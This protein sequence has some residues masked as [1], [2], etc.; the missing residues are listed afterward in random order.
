MKKISRIL[1]TVFSPLIIPTYGMILA[2]YLSILAYLPAGVLWSSIGVVFVITCLVPATAIYA[3]FKSGFVS[4]AGLNERTD[5]T[6]PYI[7][8][9]LCYLGAG[10]FLLRAA[11]PVWLVMFFAGGALA[12]LVSTIVNRW[13][14]ISAHAA[15]MGGLVAML[16]RMAAFEV[17]LYNLNWWL[18]GAILLTGAV[19][20]A[21]VYLGRHTLLQ[22]LAGVA[23]GYICVWFLSGLFE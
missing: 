16:F 5:R 21:R 14:K 15:G 9:M 19:M 3:M 22:V 1:S 12:G 17:S 6:I 2:S 7:I 4:D 18:C 20:T 11:A 8:V 10:F 23:N 13:W